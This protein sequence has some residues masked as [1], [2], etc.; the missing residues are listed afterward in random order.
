[1]AKQCGP[2]PFSG[3]IGNVCFYKMGD[4]Y[5]ARMKSSLSGKRVKKDPAFRRTME[6]ANILAEA[7]RIASRVYRL[8]PKEEKEQS[9]YREMTGAAMRT[10]KEGVKPEE[11]VPWLT[12]LYVSRPDAANNKN[13][14][15]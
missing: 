13:P 8:I 2:L 10:L 6:H 9:L 15:R 11:I 12:D 4:Q 5:Y 7:S 14:R 3:T 1:M